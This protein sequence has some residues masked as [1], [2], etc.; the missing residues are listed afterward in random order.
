MQ[1]T[2]QEVMAVPEV[3]FT[4]TW[5]PYHHGA[6]I[7]HAEA[8][9]T[10][11]GI[12]IVKERYELSE[13]GKDMFTTWQ[14]GGEC[15]GA[16]NEIGFRNSMQKRFPLGAVAGLTVMVCSNLCLSGDWMELLKH[17]SGLDDDRIAHMFDRA[18]VELGT[19]LV[20]YNS[21]VDSLRRHAIDDGQMKQLTYDA[22]RVGVFS[23]SRFSKFLLAYGE[24]TEI[25][26][27]NSLYNF[28]MAATRLMRDEGL[29]RVQQRNT[30]L[31][32]LL[33]EYAEKLA[34]P[35]EIRVRGGI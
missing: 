5:H 6:V 4:K 18:I 13:N 7:E 24:E 30:A 33:K 35:V 25:N 21:W 23:P 10:R 28:Q 3:P 1:A 27:T 32:R 22:M 2:K 14:I 16:I 26:R 11:A 15:G 34:D 31:E 8:A 12:V 19:R 29:F 17:T 20:D 9:L